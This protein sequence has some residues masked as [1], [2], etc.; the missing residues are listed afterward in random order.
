MEPPGWA[1]P[2]DYPV[3]V[4]GP[5]FT[6]APATLFTPHRERLIGSSYM[7]DSFQRS[8]ASISVHLPTY[9]FTRRPSRRPFTQHLPHLPYP[10]RHITGHITDLE[11]SFFYFQGQVLLKL[12]N[13]PRSRT[14]HRPNS[15]YRNSNPSVSPSSPSHLHPHL[16]LHLHATTHQTDS[17]SRHHPTSTRSNEAAKDSP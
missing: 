9:L 17:P 10:P 5:Y 7:L 8:L 14:F 12:W 3:H 4:Y 15:L 16:H 13:L 11:N 6:S 1:L 2:T